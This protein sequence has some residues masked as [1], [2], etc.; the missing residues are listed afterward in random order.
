MQGAVK[1]KALDETDFNWNPEN[2]LLLNVLNR[3]VK[4]LNVKIN[5]K[6]SNYQ[7]S[8][9]L[10]VETKEWFQSEN[11]TPFSSIWICD[12]LDIN[13]K[14]FYIKALNSKRKYIDISTY[15]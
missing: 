6:A 11:L 12:C 7:E 9:R 3:A 10:M 8:K 2:K 15:C 14:Q 13:P 1:L 4:D 5:P